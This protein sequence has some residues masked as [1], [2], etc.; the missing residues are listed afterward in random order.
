MLSLEEDMILKEVLDYIPTL[1]KERKPIL[2]SLKRTLAED[3]VAPEALPPCDYALCDGYALNSHLTIGAAKNNPKYFSVLGE[4]CAGAIYE[5]EIKCNGAVNIMTGASIPKGTDCVIQLELVERQDELLIVINQVQSGMN[6]RMA[7]SDLAKGSI[8]INSGSII[9]PLEIGV[10]AS[11]GRS[12][13][14]VIRRPIVS[15]AATGDE[16]IP[17][18]GKKDRG[19]VY[20][21]NAH[22]IAG[23]VSSYGGTPRLLDVIPDDKNKLRD[24]IIR[25]FGSDLLITIGGTSSGLKDIVSEHGFEEISYGDSLYHNGLP[26]KILKG[27]DNRILPHLALPGKPVGSI[28]VFELYGRSVLEKMSGRRRSTFKV[29]CATMQNEIINAGKAN[30]YARVKLQKKQEFY[31][32][33]ST[34]KPDHDL[35]CP[36]VEAN[37]FVFLPKTTEKV[38]IGD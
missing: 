36:N 32:A 7:G 5:G 9:S 3:I 25:S 10:L 13:A 31:I 35:I 34:G 20:N 17:V 28:I 12:S 29:C 37:G 22:C 24:S 23:L 19:Q 30:I 21:S 26:L 6:V 4:V 16:V 1:S 33:W 38:C 8:V 15:V 11:L 2:E 14:E 27:T 18:G